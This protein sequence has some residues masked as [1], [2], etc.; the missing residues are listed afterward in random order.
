MTMVG[1]LKECFRIHLY[2]GRGCK[3]DTG[4]LGGL[5]ELHHVTQSLEEQVQPTKRL[6]SHVVLILTSL[7]GGVKCISPD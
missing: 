3:L 7:V 1:M 5:Q 6:L 4:G 2:P